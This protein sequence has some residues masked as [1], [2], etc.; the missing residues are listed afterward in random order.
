MM[1]RGGVGFYPN[2]NFIHLDTGSV[3]TWSIGSD[4]IMR[5]A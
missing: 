2:K 5:G 3:R 4:G 1:Q